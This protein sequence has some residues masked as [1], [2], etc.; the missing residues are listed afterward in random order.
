MAVGLFDGESD[1]EETSAALPAL[2]DTSL[3]RKSRLAN[4]YLTGMYASAVLL[5]SVG[6]VSAIDP[7]SRY[8][9]GELAVAGLAV[10]VL[11]LRGRTLTDRV[12]AFT[13]FSGAFFLIGTLATIIVIGIN[14]P[15]IRLA[16]VGAVAVVGVL[17]VLGGVLLVGAKLSPITLRRIE[18]LEFMCI[19][20]VAPLAFWIIGAYSAVR[21]R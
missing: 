5:I 10:M 19:L 20:S 6:A 21:N 11:L 2:E 13:F 16:V 9:Y 14:V 18:Q 17:T 3:E 12:H 1:N 7:H 15:E 4:K 8:F